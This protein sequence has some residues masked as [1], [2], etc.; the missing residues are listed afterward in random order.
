[1]EPSYAAYGT[2]IQGLRKRER[3]PVRKRRITSRTLTCQRCRANK[4]GR[5]RRSR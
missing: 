4:V 3:N 1:M 2:S 5:L